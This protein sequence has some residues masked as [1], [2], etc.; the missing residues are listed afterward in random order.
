MASSVVAGEKP[1]RAQECTA[2]QNRSQ[3]HPEQLAGRAI[4]VRGAVHGSQ[5]GWGLPLVSGRGCRVRG[6]PCPAQRCGH[7]DSRVR[8][9]PSEPADA[10]DCHSQQRV[11]GHRQPELGRQRVWLHDQRRPAPNRHRPQHD[12]PGT[13]VRDPASRGAAGARVYVSRTISSVTMRTASSAAITRRE[14]TPFPRFSPG[15]R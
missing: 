3:C 8:R 14:T 1:A 12:H 11:R 4:R 15:R 7:L 5:S 9:Q 6:Q 13:R 10:V 2:G